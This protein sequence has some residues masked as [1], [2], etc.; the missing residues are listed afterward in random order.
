MLCT[1][2]LDVLVVSQALDIQREVA[3]F[4]GRPELRQRKAEQ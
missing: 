1:K 3:G 2:S 4:L